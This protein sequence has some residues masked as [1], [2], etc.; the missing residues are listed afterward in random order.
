MWGYVEVVQC[1]F[2]EII[3]N[4]NDIIEML[5]ICDTLTSLTNTNL[6]H[7]LNQYSRLNNRMCSP[8]GFHLHTRQSFRNQYT[9]H[10]F[11]K[12]WT[13]K[14]LHLQ[15]EILRSSHRHSVSPRGGH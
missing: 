14:Y 11:G 3:E 5:I 1:P 13:H 12:V 6:F 7:R 4:R 9:T 2:K 8:Y 15:K 10:H